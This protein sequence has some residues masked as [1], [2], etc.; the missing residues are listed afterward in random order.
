[1]QMEKKIS[2]RTAKPILVTGATGY[3]GGRLV[4]RLL[5]AGYRVRAMARSLEKLRSRPWAEHEGVE[6]VAAD[7]LDLSSLRTAVRGCGVVYYLV[8]SMNQ[9]HANFAEADRRAAQNMVT[10]AAEC[11]VERIIYLGGLGEESADLSEHLR[12]RAEV[13]AILRSGAVPVTVLRAAMIIGSG[14][15]SFEILRHLVE[16]LPVMV[17]PRWVMTPCQ[18]IGIRNTLAYLIGCLECPETVGQSFDIG[19]KDIVTY[20]EL[21]D[22]YA[23]EAGLRKRRIIVLPFLT[24]RLS[25]LW[26]HFFTPIP[27]S[28]ARPLIEGLRNPVVCKENRIRELIP[29]DLFDCREAIRR[30]LIRLRE[31]D[32]ETYWTDAGEIPPVE[33]MRSGDPAWARGTLKVDERHVF[34]QASAEEIWQPLVRIGG[35]TGWYYANWLWKARGFLDRLMGGVGSNRGRRDTAGLR[36]GDTVDFWRVVRVEPHRRLILLAEMKLPGEATLEFTIEQIKDNVHRLRQTARFLP[37]EF[38]GHLYWWAVS[39]FHNF[40]FNGMLGG[41]AR[42]SGKP[43][44]HGPER[45]KRDAHGAVHL[46]T[47][48]LVERGPLFSLHTLQRLPVPLAR[49]WEFFTNPQNLVSLLPPCHAWRLNPDAP[50][51]MHAGLMLTFSRRSWLGFPIKW[52]LEVTRLTEPHTFIL[53]QR[54]G[55]F[56]SWRHEHRFRQ[57]ATGVEIQDEVNYSLRFGALGRLLHHLIVKRQLCA[58]FEYRRR[59]IETIFTSAADRPELTSQTASERPQTGWVKSAE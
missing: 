7:M 13:A 51:R 27:A 6:L 26:I 24:P 21:F 28:L 52:V 31:D 4:P 37:R 43:I 42:A 59:A 19:G 14:S 49:I 53:E 38:W 58:M 23:E 45:V 35:T 17:T 44:L 3:V 36:L 57:L 56:K 41:V 1:M 10:V 34:L 11:E 15:A 18:P 46:P 33:W 47:V 30:T 32:L 25:S 50:P 16:R 22:I 54:S 2:E 12:S 40:V 9:Q 20:R 55:F 8:H 48:C 39:P 5:E 29:L